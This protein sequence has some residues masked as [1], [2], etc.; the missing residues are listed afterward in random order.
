MKTEESISPP[1]TPAASIS[2]TTK[3][4]SETPIG[5]TGS[6]SSLA[7]GPNAGFFLHFDKKLS[8]CVKKYPCLYDSKTV[9][10]KDKNVTAQ[11]WEMV[12]KEV[13]V[14]SGGFLFFFFSVG[15]ILNRQYIFDVL[16]TYS[17]RFICNFVAILS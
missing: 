9:G 7:T 16:N 17:E 6:E 3:T 4:T 5:N 15:K 11:Y 12:A 10:Y 13:Q 2:A 14:E 8:D 1:S